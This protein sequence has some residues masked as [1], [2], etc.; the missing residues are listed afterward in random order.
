VADAADK[1]RHFDWQLTAAESALSSG[2]PTV[3]EALLRPLTQTEAT[4]E[5]AQ[6]QRAQLLLVD[7]LMAQRRF[8]EAQQSL[9]EVSGS[10]SAAYYLRRALF[11]YY[12]RDYIGLEQDLMQLRPEQLTPDDRPWYHL[13]TGLL[14]KQAGQEALAE[15]AFEQ[16]KR[17]ST[18]PLQKAQFEAFVLSGSILSGSIDAATLEQMQL[19]LQTHQ[20]SRL[21]TDFARQYAVALHQ[22]GQS[23]AAVD[24]LTS[25]LKVLT[26]D[27]QRDEASLLLLIGL[28]AGADTQRGQTALLDVLKR[29]DQPALLRVALYQLLPYLGPQTEASAT[30][31]ALDQLMGQP[32]HPIRDELLMVR[33]R[34]LEAQ[35]LRS[36]AATAAETLLEAYPRSPY[37]EA[38][39]W[40]LARL[41]WTDTPP[42]YRSAAEVLSR[43]RTQLPAG[44]AKARVTHLMADCYYLKG[45]YSTAADLYLSVQADADQPHRRSQAAYQHVLAQL[46]SGDWQ[47]ALTALEQGPLGLSQLRRWQAEWNLAQAMVEAGE[48]T[49]AT[50]RLSRLVDML[51]G[52]PLRSTEEML[53]RFRWLQ[54]TLHMRLGSWA[55][56][57]QQ[58]RELQA[59]AS[60][61]A[62]AVAAVAMLHE[63]QALVGLGEGQAALKAFSALRQRYPDSEPAVL[64]LL[65]EARF[66]AQRYELANAQ[67]RLSELA[68]AYQANR[69]A[70]TA[71]LEAALLAQQQ[72]QRHHLEEAM[73]LTQRF[74][75]RYPEHALLFRV[76][77]LQ[78]N[79]ARQLG[80]FEAALQ[81]Y[82][83]LLVTFRDTDHPLYL[84]ELY[85]ANTLIAQASQ[86]PG[87]RD[88]AA[89]KLEG[90]FSQVE[91][92]ADV[93]A[94]AAYTF[95][96][97]HRETD[98][99]M[100][101]LEID[102]LA[103]DRLLNDP[104]VELGTRGR[105]WMA[106]ILLDMAE[107]LHKLGRYREAQHA[108]RQILNR[109]LPGGLLAQTRI[110]AL[111]AAA[112]KTP[113]SHPND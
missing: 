109:Q 16:A 111:A 9:R 112:N 26:A 27:E 85:A 15:Q 110:E 58:A 47:A 70:P 38:A 87:K 43:L 17:T 18:T 13:L 22:S 45:D 12:S 66:Y 86:Q 44:R 2:L 10:P 41:A 79:L 46:A 93:R 37:Q 69:N 99:Q 1:R 6:L 81:T 7:V 60:P 98:G 59:L 30:V 8:E 113:D 24:V 55:L 19:R 72:G 95:S 76:R 40:L 54:T 100:R 31:T 75:E 73:K 23:E 78:G 56:A 68:D 21:S 77:L 63:A 11:Y 65:E 39:L 62:P 52:S 50:E 33:A 82:E 48:V 80:D 32:A 20:N 42:R 102:Y 97:L 90:I 107:T 5:A 57:L 34:L 91:V 101:A 108:Y 28:V 103:I 106:R 35:G 104:E 14:K 84:A 88:L 4:S 49:L 67:R 105:Y 64:S 61:G 92:P 53:L 36:E 29:S 83:R 89:L 74:A 94:E 25:Q 51:A 71:L 3:A 96:R